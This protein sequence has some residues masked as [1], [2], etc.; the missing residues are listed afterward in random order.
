MSEHEPKK[1]GPKRIYGTRQEFHF[2][3]SQ[4]LAN[5]LRQVANNNVQAYMECI[6]RERPEVQE[7]LKEGK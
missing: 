5:A 3:L 6:L 2:K 4:D 7:I 1:R